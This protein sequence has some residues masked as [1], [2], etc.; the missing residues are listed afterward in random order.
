M[1]VFYMRLTLRSKM[2]HTPRSKLLNA[3]EDC[4]F[5]PMIR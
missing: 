4:Q 3:N 1:R 2:N 5:L